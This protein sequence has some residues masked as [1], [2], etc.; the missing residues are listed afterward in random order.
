MKLYPGLNYKNDWKL[1]NVQIGSNDQCASCINSV[2]PYLT[3]E[4]YGQH[5]SAAVER[6]RNEIPRVI[7]NLS[8]VLLH[9]TK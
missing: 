9:D 2:I 1:I 7:V 3:V 8:K 4:S 5:L 6:I